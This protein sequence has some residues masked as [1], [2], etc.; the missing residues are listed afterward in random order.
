MNSYF[1][2]PCP[3]FHRELI[4]DLDKKHMDKG[5]CY[6]ADGNYKGAVHTGYGIC[7]SYNT[8]VQSNGYWKATHPQWYDIKDKN[9]KRMLIIRN[10]EVIEWTYNMLNHIAH[11]DWPNTIKY[12][13]TKEKMITKWGKG[14]FKRAS[15]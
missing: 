5:L 3:W 10:T 4:I 1:T 13:V 9:I 7:L 15:I 14:G 11:H 6:L 2:P 8:E 12:I